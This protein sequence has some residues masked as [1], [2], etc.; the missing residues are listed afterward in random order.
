I[1]GFVFLVK[2]ADAFVE[3]SASLAK[4]FKVPTILIGLTVVAFG[5]SA[6]E[7]A[8]SI[9]AT[10][11]G[12]SNISIGNIVGS[13]MFNMLVVIGIAAMIKPINIK[14]KTILKEIPFLLLASITLFIL[15]MDVKFNNSNINQLALGDGIILLLIFLVFLYYLVEL[16]ITSK[17][18]SKEFDENINEQP[19][20]KS[21]LFG[22]I[23]LIGIIWGSDIVVNS[24]SH[25]AKS[26]GMSETLV[27]ISIIAVGTSLPELAT[28]MVAAF[29][30]ESDIAV[31]NAIGSTMFNT[32]LILGLASV[33][34]PIVVEQKIFTDLIFVICS[35][36][37][38]YF[39]AITNK[40]TVRWEGFILILLYIGYLIFVVL[41]N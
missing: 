13:N 10:I 41:R 24:G 32:L 27:G 8:V 37:L 14:I 4:K 35:I 7:A 17:D 29:K 23:G 6:P 25:I 34:N 38:V 30:G 1:I 15:S 36:I 40:K 19:L 2:G 5:T 21:I 39:F 18:S 16:A 3:G 28:S 12:S 20:L 26:L 11:N 9:T 31:G 22:A 33:I